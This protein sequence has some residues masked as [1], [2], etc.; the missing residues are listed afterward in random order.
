M[1]DAIVTASQTPALIAR[2][3]ENLRDREQQAVGQ[4]SE[5]IKAVIFYHFI[6]ESLNRGKWLL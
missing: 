6:G 4:D 3:S 5:R 1:A 2:A